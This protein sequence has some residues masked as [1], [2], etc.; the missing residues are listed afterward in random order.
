MEPNAQGGRACSLVR[1]GHLEAAGA[2]GFPVGDD[3]FAVGPGHSSFRCVDAPGG[4][5]VVR[6]LLMQVRRLEV[7]P[8]R[9]LVDPP[10]LLLDAANRV[11]V[12]PVIGF[13]VAHPSNLPRSGC[14]KR[15]M[16]VE[17]T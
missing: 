13:Q 3:S 9:A 14:L 11:G 1:V 16:G 12:A 15:A 2:G 5:L 7:K 17:P 4:A 10:C 6:V 8:G